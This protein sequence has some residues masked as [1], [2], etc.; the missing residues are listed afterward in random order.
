MKPILDVCC[1]SRMFYFDKENPAVI[2]MD[3]R[4]LTS[5]LC[6]GRT[7]EI[8]PDVNADFK[9]MP[10]KDNTFSLVIF[11]PPHLKQAG[12]NSWLAQKYGVLPE[13][14]QEELHQGFNEC[15]RV[16]RPYGTLIFKWNETQIKLSEVLK[17]F[18]L[19]PVMG[20]KTSKN[21]FFLVFM[22]GLKNDK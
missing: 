12:R 22:K 16:L 18:S 1:G 20:T 4:E 11:D 10:F 17:C 9:A 2:F 19:R 5:I 7:L 8:K 14:W 13:N 21:T 3:N 6:D 15:L